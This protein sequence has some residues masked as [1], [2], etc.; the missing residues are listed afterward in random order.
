MPEIGR[1]L[2]WVQSR[3]WE[4]IHLSGLTFCVAPSSIEI[5]CVQSWIKSVGH[6]LTSILTNEP[7]VFQ[8]AIYDRLRVR[9]INEA[10]KEL[11]HMITLHTGNSQ[12]LTK[13]TILQEAVNVITSLEK[14]L[15]GTSARSGRGNAG[16]M[17]MAATTRA[18][19]A[20]SRSCAR[21]FSIACS[22]TLCFVVLSCSSCAVVLVFF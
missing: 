12:S 5:F 11:G 1:G 19:H 3:S 18:W 2:F 14:Q 20:R 22:M 6:Q 21:A 15:R 9:D 17:Q 7:V 10:I 16:S 8:T 13:L 4:S